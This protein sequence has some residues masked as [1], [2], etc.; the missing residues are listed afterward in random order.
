[1]ISPFLFIILIIVVVPVSDLIIAIIPVFVYAQIKK[2]CVLLSTIRKRRA[3]ICYQVH[4]QGQKFSH[5]LDIL[6]Y[7]RIRNMDKEGNPLS[8]KQEILGLFPESMW[9]RLGVVSEYA[10]TLQ[11]IRL[12]TGRPVLL[13]RDHTERCIDLKGRIVTETSGAW[14]LLPGEL[15]SILNHICHYSLY[16]YAEELR[17]GFLTVPGGHR[18]G[19]AGSAV[20]NENGEILSLKHIS[21]LNIR[22]SH[23]IKGVADPVLPFLYQKKELLNTLILS[24]PGCGK[25]TMLRDLVRQISDGSNDCHGRNVTV[26]DERSEI[27][28]TYMGTAQND[29]GIRTDVLDGCPKVQ[30]M[31]MAVR[32]L[33]PDVVAVDE[34]GGREDAA[35]LSQVLCCGSSLVATAHGSSIEDLGRKDWMKPVL[36]GKMFK[37]I[38]VLGRKQ[39]KCI[40]AG[41]YDQDGRHV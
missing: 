7:I 1:M 17:R 37:R 10:D 28:G 30:G 12:R 3:S 38:V 36:E 13:V 41:I 20:L 31:M 40:V 14:I 27:A 39:G 22:I 29:V 11:E 21:G 19:V 16:A 24:P 15:E 6:S 18:V 32:S 35:A 5:K 4:N 26:I 8:R 23:E 34:I 25:T 33:T 9:E 2:Y